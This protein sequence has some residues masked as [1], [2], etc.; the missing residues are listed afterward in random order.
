MVCPNQLLLGVVLTL[1]RRISQQAKTF[2]PYTQG[3]SKRAEVESWRAAES[4]HR[5]RRLHRSA[6]IEI[7]FIRLLVAHSFA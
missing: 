4:A 7:P 2:S 6:Y 5:Q 1:R 3:T